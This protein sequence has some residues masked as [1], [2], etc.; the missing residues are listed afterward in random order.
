[1]ESLHF[2]Y[3]F[4]RVDDKIIYGHK[5]VL[6]TASPR[7]RN[8]FKSTMSDDTAPTIQIKDIRYHIFQVRLVDK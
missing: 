8:M 6:I 5:I 4:G 7:F 3:S 1:M 2:M